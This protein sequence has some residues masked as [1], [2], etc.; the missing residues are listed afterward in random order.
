MYISAVRNN[1]A[2]CSRYIS[3]VRMTRYRCNE[4]HHFIFN[5][6]YCSWEQN[7]QLLIAF[8][9]KD[10]TIPPVCNLKRHQEIVLP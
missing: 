9:G 10:Q 3:V 5:F 1:H 6:N 8:Q 4:H 2:Y 7:K